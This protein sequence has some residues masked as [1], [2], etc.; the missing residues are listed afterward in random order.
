MSDLSIDYYDRNGA[1]FFARTVDADMSADHARFLNH[2]PPGGSILEAGCGSGRDALAFANAGYT[3]TA[4]DG[5]AEMVRLA[6]AHTGLPVLHKRFDEIEWQGAFDGIWA[7]A[8]LLHI[9]RAELPAIMARIARALKPGGVWYMSFKYGDHEAVV[10]ER[11]FTYMTEPLLTESIRSLGLAP[12]DLWA[13][14]DVRAGRKGET[15]LSVIARK[16]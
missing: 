9:P 16:H 15:W 3:V 10:H 5:S 14:E 2:I 12:I 8:S 13:S 4:M 7:N 1:T 11:H 6:T